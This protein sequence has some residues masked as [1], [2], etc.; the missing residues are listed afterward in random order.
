M[1]NNHAFEQCR[2][3]DPGETLISYTLD[4]QSGCIVTC[5]INNIG[6]KWFTKIPLFILVIVAGA[7]GWYIARLDEYSRPQRSRVA[8]KAKE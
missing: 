4:E 1:A 6:S 3:C 2:K 5:Q 7:I 8:N